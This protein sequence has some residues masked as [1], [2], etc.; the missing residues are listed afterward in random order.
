MTI[1]AKIEV[2]TDPSYEPAQSKP[3]DDKYFFSYHIRIRHLGGEPCQLINRHWLITDASGE[4]QEVYGEG[5]IGKKP[6]FQMG[7]EFEYTSGVL[8]ETPVGTMEGYYEM[9][10]ESGEMFRVTI[11]PFL[12]ALP[13]TIN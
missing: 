11:H 3:E 6:K 12:L 9:Q 8:L 10:A 13:G 1:D 4:K 7:Q 2:L 5:V